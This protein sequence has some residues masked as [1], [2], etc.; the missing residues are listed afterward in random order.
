MV[1][2]STDWKV[3][4]SAMG[5]RTFNPIRHIV[6]D[7]PRPQGHAKSF[8]PL[9]IGDPTVFKN[10][11]RS[12]EI[13]KA[14][15][16]VLESSNFDGYPPS[17]GYVLSRKAVAEFL[18]STCGVETSSDDIILTSG[19]SHALDMVISSLCNPGDQLLIPAPGFSLYRTICESY[20]FDC[21]PYPLQVRFFSITYMF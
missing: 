15:S 12:P 5:T 14:I 19:C 18:S 10:L 6:D 7:M 16:N 11:S 20:G 2:S 4:S 21:I 1:D 9:S 8:I 13:S 3:H 17:T